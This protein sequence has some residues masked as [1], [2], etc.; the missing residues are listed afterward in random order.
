[1]NVQMEAKLDFPQRGCALHPHY[2]HPHPAEF[3]CMSLGKNDS[4]AF[5]HAQFRTCK[6]IPKNHDQLT[7]K[8]VLYTKHSF[9]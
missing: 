4:T 7:Q 6:V 5:C 3:F 9:H 2:P 1:M 8:C